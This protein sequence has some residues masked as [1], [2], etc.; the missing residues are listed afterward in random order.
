MGILPLVLLC[1][2]AN[3]QFNNLPDSIRVEFPEEKCIVSFE[4]RNFQEQKEIITQFPRLLQSLT[5]Q[6]QNIM[7]P[8]ELTTVHNVSVKFSKKSPLR[9]QLKRLDLTTEPRQVTISPASHQTSFSSDGNVLRELLPPGWTM[10]FA[11]DVFLIT[12]YAHTWE[13]IKALAQG[14]LQH[15]V[16]ALEKNESVKNVGRRGLSARMVSSGGTIQYEKIDRKPPTDMLGLHAGA[17]VGLY[18]GKW[19]PELNFATALYFSNRMRENNQRLMLAYELKFFPSA[20]AEGNFVTSNNGFL[21]FSYSRNFAKQT[22]RWTGLGV[23]YLVNSKGTIY[24]NETIKFFLE[25]DIGSQKLNIV[26]EFYLINDFKD[27]S[28]GLKLNYRF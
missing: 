16:A 27:F 25:T 21:N 12:M 9:F 6:L 1:L 26:P 11:S 22:P 15:I 17:A 10:T 5:E 20:D 23:G 14:D 8:E 2:S 24:T 13:N 7:V 19:Y 18:N 3:A 28:L 4:L